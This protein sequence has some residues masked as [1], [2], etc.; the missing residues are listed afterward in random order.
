MTKII[1][2]SIILAFRVFF[3][4]LFCFEKLWIFLPIINHYAVDSD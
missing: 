3:L 1:T 4:F 2:A